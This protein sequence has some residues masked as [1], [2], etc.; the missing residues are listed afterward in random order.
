MFAWGL[1]RSVRRL[2]WWL[3]CG[4]RDKFEFEKRHDKRNGGG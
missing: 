1:F 3:L 4:L 2:S